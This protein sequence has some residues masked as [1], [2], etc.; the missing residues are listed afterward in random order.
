MGNLPRGGSKLK[1]DYLGKWV[2]IVNNPPGVQKDPLAM[3][4]GG[5]H[6][7]IA[8][9]RGRTSRRN[10]EPPA[11]NQTRILQIKTKRKQEA[12]RRPKGTAG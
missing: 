1:H 7:A 3:A 2:H 9:S 8:R 12:E 4:G 5:W 6:V 10:S 11:G